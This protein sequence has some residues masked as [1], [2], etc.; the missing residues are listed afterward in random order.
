MK[1]YV[2]IIWTLVFSW[3]TQGVSTAGDMPTTL[4]LSPLIWTASVEGSEDFLT[5]GTFDDTLETLVKIYEPGDV[6][7]FQVS[8]PLNE[9]QL[10]TPHA[11]VLGPVHINSEV[12]F[13]GILVGASGHIS[14]RARDNFGFAPGRETQLFLIPSTINEAGTYA[15][16]IRAQSRVYR[17]GPVRGPRAIMPLQSAF[18]TVAANNQYLIAIESFWVVASLLI[19]VFTLSRIGIRGAPQSR[20]RWLPFVLIF[21]LLSL[22][23][24]TFLFYDLGLVTPLTIRIGDSYPGHLALLL[25]IFAALGVERQVWQTALITTLACIIG[26]LAWWDGSLAFVTAREVLVTISAVALVGLCLYG[27]FKAMRADTRVSPWTYASIIWLIAFVLLYALLPQ[28]MDLVADPAEL[29]LVIWMIILTLA[30]ADHAKWDREAVS[31]LT[32]ELLSSGEK[33][34]GRV[35]RELH[36]GLSHRLALTRMRLESLLRNAGDFKGQLEEPIAELSTSSEEIAAI[37]EGLRPLSLSGGDLQIALQSFAARWN[38]L[39]DI[40]VETNIHADQLP[41]EEAQLHL[42][43]ITQEAVQNAV[44]HG[45][46]TKIKIVLT[47]SLDMLTLEI[48]DNGSGF[49][50]EMLPTIHGIGLTAMQQRIELLNG[51]LDV[52]SRPGDGTTIRARVPLT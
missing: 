46:A 16:T 42:L 22:G 32:R 13:D 31:I 15:L 25:H 2:L 9:Q 51:A 20:D 4:D 3:F 49:Q 39:S 40:K 34:R 18:E 11:I 17:P 33:E 27:A 1:P 38:R 41:D 19:V 52:E 26:G 12:Y 36:D 35:A 45:A 28:R 30:A 7:L 37:A 44:R 23:N 6:A 14:H 43:R 8:V 47:G 48:Q 5:Q 50:F 29:L 21:G 24:Q 10:A